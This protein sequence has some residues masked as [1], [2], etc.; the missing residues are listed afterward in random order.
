[1]VGETTLTFFQEIGGD[2]PF[3]VG[4]CGWALSPGHLPARFSFRRD[5]SV[6]AVLFSLFLFFFYLHVAAPALCQS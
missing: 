2:G 4:L 5:A 6:G 1:M 3:S